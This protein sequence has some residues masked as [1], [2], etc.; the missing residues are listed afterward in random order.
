[1]YKA[2][3]IQPQNMYEASAVQLQ[4]MYKV[5]AVQL[6][7]STGLKSHYTQTQTQNHKPATHDYELTESKH[8]TPL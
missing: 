3:A 6:Q 5:S 4:V 8:T 2:S 1:M 7:V